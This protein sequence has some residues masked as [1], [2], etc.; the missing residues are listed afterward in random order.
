VALKYADQKEGQIARQ[1]DKHGG[2]NSVDIIDS[3]T[4]PEWI[5]K[6]LNDLS[7]EWDLPD[8]VDVLLRVEQEGDADLLNGAGCSIWMSWR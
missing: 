5:G 4:H 8:F 1:I 7:Q 6:S 3:K 2:G